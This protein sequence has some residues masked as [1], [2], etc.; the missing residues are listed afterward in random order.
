VYIISPEA[1]LLHFKL[2]DTNNFEWVVAHLGKDSKDVKIEDAKHFAD[3]NIIGSSNGY[4]CSTKKGDCHN[5]NVWSLKDGK[6]TTVDFGGEGH[7]E[8]QSV[9]FIEGYPNVG[10]VCVKRGN[11]QE[12]VLH[13]FQANKQIARISTGTV[14]FKA[15]KHVPERG[16]LLCSGFEFFTLLNLSHVLP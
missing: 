16:V 12:I 15:I 6:T 11:D 4:I 10:A 7:P 1:L 3:F 5:L 14:S 9:T 2:K 8:L 13:D